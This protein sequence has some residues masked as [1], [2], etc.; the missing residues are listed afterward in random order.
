MSNFEY[1]NFK[2]ED[3]KLKLDKM[4][5]SDIQ[6]HKTD[7]LARLK[8]LLGIDRSNEIKK[9]GFVKDFELRTQVLNVIKARGFSKHQTHATINTLVDALE[10]NNPLEPAVYGKD[11]IERVNRYI[12]QLIERDERFFPNFY[13]LVDELCL[14]TNY[15]G[16]S[17]M[18]KKLDN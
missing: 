9:R 11:S 3:D 7:D 16:V 13:K 14:N 4:Y 8:L 2:K 1:G 10:K 18:F 6:D 17:Y 15:D 5:G 12:D